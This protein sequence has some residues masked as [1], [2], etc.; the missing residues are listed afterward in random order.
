MSPTVAG[1]LIRCS[2]LFSLQERG[3]IKIYLLS[4]LITSFFHT[5]HSHKITLKRQSTG[6]IAFVRLQKGHL[7]A[8]L[9][10][11]QGL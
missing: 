6:L 11:K 7:T 5:L 8:V 10:G 3:A 1:T 4:H 2:V 9:L